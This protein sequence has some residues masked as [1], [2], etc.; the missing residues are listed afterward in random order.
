MAVLD[1]AI[2]A[3]FLRVG[4]ATIQPSPRNAN[5]HAV[6]LPQQVNHYE[7]IPISACG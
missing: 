7:K 4:A 3:F 5:R 2:H 1:T 6:R